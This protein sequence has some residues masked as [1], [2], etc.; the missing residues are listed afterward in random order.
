[1]EKIIDERIIMVDMAAIDQFS[2]DAFYCSA[3]LRTI[4]EKIDPLRNVKTLPR[5]LLIVAQL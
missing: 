1:M 4:K 3:R 2:I 5:L